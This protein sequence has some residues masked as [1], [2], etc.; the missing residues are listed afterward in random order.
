MKKIS[1]A[2]NLGLVTLSFAG[3]MA[4]SS[5]NAQTFLVGAYLFGANGTGATTSPSYQF[6]TNTNN[7]T[8]ALIVNGIGKGFTAPLSLG[9]NA[10]TFA[11]GSSAFPLSGNGDLGLFFD[12][13]NNPYSPL[14][15][16]RTPDLLVS[17]DST[18][19][20]AFFVPASG[21]TINDFHYSPS[22]LAANGL[23]TFSLGGQT[24]AVT[25]YSVNTAPAGTFTLN[26]TP[27]VAPT[28]EPGVTGLLVGLGVSGGAFAL[29]RRR[30]AKK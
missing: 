30:T 5:A 16:S 4:T 26:V 23:P 25:A 17:R 15:T 10:F 28:P 24:I 13:V 1:S 14:V 12:T 9:A 18:G 19:A 27:F 20:L 29:R 3:L 22:T 8:I 11:G 6:D 7:P 2:V 21:T